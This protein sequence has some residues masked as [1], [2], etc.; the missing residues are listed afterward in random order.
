M[1][2]GAGPHLEGVHSKD[3][4]GKEVARGMLRWYK[5]KAA[6]VRITECAVAGG[7]A[8][9]VQAP[10]GREGQ[11]LIA[12][13]EKEEQSM[14]RPAQFGLRF[15][16]VI[17]MVSLASI[18]FSSPGPAGGPYVSALSSLA[19]SDAY[20]ASHPHCFRTCT[21]KNTCTTGTLPTVCLTSNGACSTGT[22]R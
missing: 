4:P 17:A 6:R 19:V 5:N 13:F 9:E 14:P 22:C 3:P 11:S 10:F 20:A 2:R 16:A 7:A 15:L 12:R 21:P 18:Y 1:R 8:G